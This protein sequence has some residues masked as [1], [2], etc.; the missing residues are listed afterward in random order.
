MSQCQ[1]FDM[2]IGCLI[3]CYIGTDDMIWLV[4]LESLNR[5]FTMAMT[6]FPDI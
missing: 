6:H 3:G 4:I 2:K 5:S 1:V